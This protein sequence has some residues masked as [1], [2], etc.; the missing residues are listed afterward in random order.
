MSTAILIP[1]RYNS[2]RFPGKMLADLNGKTLIERVYERSSETGFDVYVLTDHGKI[3]DKF[4]RSSVILQAPSET[5]RNGTERCRHAVQTDSR[6]EN[7]TKFINVQGDMPDITPEIIIA[8]RRML[9]DYDVSTAYTDIS[10]QD[11]KDPNVVKAIVYG[12]EL[13]WCGRGFTQGFRHLGIYGYSK[14]VIRNH[15]PKEQCNAEKRSNLEQLRWLE[16]GTT[17]GAVK[18]DF[19]GL[20]INTPYDLDQWRLRNPYDNTERTYLGKP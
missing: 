14:H 9:R 18:V 6:L 11:R 15:Y 13:E 17:I 10:D 4:D 8:V 5:I 20:E 2:S 7:Y 19:E 3:M 16:N 1:A 12:D